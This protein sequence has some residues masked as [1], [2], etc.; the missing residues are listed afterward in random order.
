MM[1]PRSEDDRYI[2]AV[3]VGWGRSE[4]FEC[5]DDYEMWMRWN[6]KLRDIYVCL[7]E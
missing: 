7:M 2:A 5:L 4:L 3:K 6:D 1:V